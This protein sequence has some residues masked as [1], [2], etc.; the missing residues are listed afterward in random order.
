MAKRE[1]ERG[2]TAATR[3]AQSEP[4]VRVEYPREGEVITHPTYTF[5]VGAAPDLGSVEVSIDRGE[6]RPCRESLGLWWFD[7]TD[8]SKGRHVLLARARLGEGIASVSDQ[9]RFTVD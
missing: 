5:Q 6:W 7:W 1:R 3:M 2:R 4:A 9:R 8:Y